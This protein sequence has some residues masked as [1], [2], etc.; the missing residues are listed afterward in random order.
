MD[1]SFNF[2]MNDINAD[3][4]NSIPSSVTNSVANGTV[5]SSTAAASMILGGFFAFFM[6]SVCIIGLVVTILNIIA[7][8]KIFTKAGQAGW[9]S[10][11]PIYNTVVLYKVAGISPL[12]VLSY[13]VFWVPILGPLFVLGVNIYAMI[14]L[15]RAFGKED[16][17]AVGLVLLNTIFI[18]I[19]GFGK[20]EYQL[21]KSKEA[22]IVEEV[23]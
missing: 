2:A 4:L 23:K 7:T 17:F 6:I 15:S 21:N 13:L 9:K 10:L 8:W 20:S 18:M 3:I 5:N 1:L 19:L 11:I 22:E 12:W 16:V 14:N